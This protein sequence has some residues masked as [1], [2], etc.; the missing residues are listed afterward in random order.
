[1]KSIKSTAVILLFSLLALGSFDENP[2][3][4]EAE[5]SEVW[6][7]DHKPE[8]VQKLTPKMIEIWG[9]ILSN[10]KSIFKGIFCNGKKTDVYI[11]RKEWAELTEF[12]ARN[13]TLLA[14][15][16]P[17]TDTTEIKFIDN[18]SKEILAQFTPTTPSGV[19]KIVH[20]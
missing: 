10:P 18:E 2:K 14:L 9:G 20:P 5:S 16:L 6:T 19:T 12:Q 4:S 17:R 1:M 13:N 11:N 8:W 7:G 3:P 15:T